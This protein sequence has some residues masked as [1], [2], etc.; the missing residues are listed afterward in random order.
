MRSPRPIL[1]A[2]LVRLTERVGQLRLPDAVALLPLLALIPVLGYAVHAVPLALR[3]GYPVAVVLNYPA[4]EAALDGSLF[5]L[6]T[7]VVAAFLVLLFASQ[8]R[9][10]EG[11]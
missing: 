2:L 11:L 5:L 6:R 7:L 8:H 1:N 9:L 10:T 4:A 3:A